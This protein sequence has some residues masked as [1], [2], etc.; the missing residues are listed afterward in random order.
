MS[1]RRRS[2]HGHANYGKGASRRGGNAPGFAIQGNPVTVV[3]RRYAEA[4]AVPEP[5]APVR[6]IADMSDEEIAALERKYGAPVRRPRR[7]APPQRP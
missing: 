4:V 1:R 2:S 6:T 7:E 3:R 5:V